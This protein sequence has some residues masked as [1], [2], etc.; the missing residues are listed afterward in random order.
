MEV[1]MSALAVVSGTGM[2]MTTLSAKSL[3]PK[4]ALTLVLTCMRVRPSSL[5][6][7]TTCAARPDSS[8]LL[9][10]LKYAAVFTC[11][12]EIVYSSNLR[13]QMSHISIQKILQKILHIHM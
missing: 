1:W 7:G 6:S 8:A 5:I 9:P 2:V 11:F 10:P 12:P 3:A 13:H 4:P